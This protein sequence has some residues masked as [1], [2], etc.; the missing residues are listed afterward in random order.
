MAKKLKYY[1]MVQIIN[2]VNFSKDKKDIPATKTDAGNKFY[3]SLLKEK[4]DNPEAWFSYPDIDLMDDDEE[5]A[6]Q[7]AMFGGEYEDDKE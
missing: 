7:D 1:D 5:E 3:E 4:K 2:G 6:I